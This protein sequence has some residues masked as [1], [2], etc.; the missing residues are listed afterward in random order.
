MDDPALPAVPR[1][2]R[3]EEPFQRPRGADSPGTQAGPAR[4]VFR[5]LAGGL[6]LV[7]LLVGLL[8]WL[9]PQPPTYLVPL[10]VTAYRSGDIPA[11]PWAAQDR[12]ALSQGGYF[13]RTA[14]SPAP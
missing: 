2:W 4:W 1:R 14:E 11:P 5:L 6:V 3:E 7:V 13:S 12:E 9:R 8:Y 10:W